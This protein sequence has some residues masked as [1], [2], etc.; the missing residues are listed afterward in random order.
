MK[1]AHYPGLPHSL[2]GIVANRWRKDQQVYIVQ[3]AK[4]S[5][6]FPRPKP[7]GTDE[8]LIVNLGDKLFHGTIFFLRCDE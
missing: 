2:C 5:T 8:S 6:K 3:S 1:N 7:T 4:A